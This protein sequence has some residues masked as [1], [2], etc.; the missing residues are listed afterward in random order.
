MFF[1]LSFFVRVCV[2]A[3]VRVRDRVVWLRVVPE[4][5]LLENIFELVWCELVCVLGVVVQG[6]VAPRVCDEVGYALQIICAFEAEGGLGSPL[7]LFK[8]EPCVGI[9]GQVQHLLQCILTF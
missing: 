9:L 8:V 4:L 5:L 6:A 1:V 3:S 7:G 2:C